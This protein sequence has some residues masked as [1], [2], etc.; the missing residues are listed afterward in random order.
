M[1]SCFLIPA[2]LTRSKR[3]SR[4][5]GIVWAIVRTAE[6]FG[7]TEVPAMEVARRVGTDCRHVTLLYRDLV[8]EGLMETRKVAGSPKDGRRGGSRR[9][10]ARALWPEWL[11]PGEE[12]RRVLE[13]LVSAS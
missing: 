5:A 8:R 6:A 9:L 10:Y 7:E 2:E 12:F 3:V 4:M 11:G 13:V 1:R